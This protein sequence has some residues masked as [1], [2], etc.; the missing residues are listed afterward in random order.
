MLKTIPAFAI[1]ADC[2]VWCI[3]LLLSYWTRVW[4]QVNEFN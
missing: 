2:C 1:A 4:T 3:G